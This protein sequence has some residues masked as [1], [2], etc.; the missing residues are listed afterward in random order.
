MPENMLLLPLCQ[1]KRTAAAQLLLAHV[2][3]A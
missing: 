2:E 1:H 3:R